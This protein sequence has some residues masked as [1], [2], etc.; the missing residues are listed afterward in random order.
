VKEIEL[1]PV[2]LFFQIGVT[3]YAIDNPLTTW[4]LDGGAPSC[5]ACGKSIHLDWDSPPKTGVAMCGCN[6]N[7]A[8]DWRA[9]TLDHLDETRKMVRRLTRPLD[10]A[11][12]TPEM[13]HFMDRVD[14]ILAANPNGLTQE[15]LITLLMGETDS[16]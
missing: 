15:E 8:A 4:R 12:V 1:N 10:P 2:P 13:R 3:T 9:V 6:L 16:N 7:T 14:K 5:S 11:T